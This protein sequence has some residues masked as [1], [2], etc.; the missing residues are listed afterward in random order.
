MLKLVDIKK[1]YVM[2]DTKVEALKGLSINFRRNEFVSILGPSGCG[3]TT[4]LN[5]IGGLDKYTS[6]DLIINGVSTKEF[7]DRNWD[8]YRNHRIGFIFQSYNLIPHQTILE[9]VELALTI[10]GMGKQER[11]EKA[12]NA[13]DRVGLA[14]QYHKRPNQLSGGQCQRVA[15][16]RALVNE[17]E[18]LLADEPTGALDTVTSKQIM[19]LIKE[20][21]KEK[22][23]IMVTHNPDLA[24]EY[25][26]R[27]VRLLDGQINS[28]SNPCS[29]EVET[30]E[31]VV[32][33]EETKIKEKAKMSFWT[34][35]KLS[36]RNL[37]SKFK[38]TLMVGLAGSIGI[39]G[40]S[41]VLAL[42]S[43]ITDYIDNL[44]EDM[45]SGNPITITEQTY[46]LNGMMSS[47]SSFEVAETVIKNGEV[48]VNSMLELLAKRQK[49]MDN[50]FITNEI[51][52][53]Y[54]DYL[55][56]MPK[57]Y[58]E[59]IVYGYGIDITNNIYTNLKEKD[60]S[61]GLD[62]SITAIKQ[63]YKSILQQSDNDDV[64]DASSAITMLSQPMSQAI[65][66]ENYIKEQYDF[67][68]GHMATKADEIMLVVDKNRRITDLTLAEL[69]YYSQESFINFAFGAFDN[70]LGAKIKKL[71]EEKNLNIDELAAL[72]NDN[73][74]AKYENNEMIPSDAT[75]EALATAL[76]VSVDEFNGNF[77]DQNISFQDSFTYEELMNKKFTYY[78]NDVIYKSYTPSFAD[79]WSFVNFEYQPYKN[80]DFTDGL[81][82]KV[83]GILQPKDDVN[84]GTLTTGFYYTPALTDYILE[85][86]LNSEI[87]KFLK[88]H[89]EVIQSGAI[90][91]TGVGGVTTTIYKGVAYHYNFNFNGESFENQTG[92]VGSASMMSIMGD[93]F[94][95]LM[96]NLG[97]G[98]SSSSQGSNVSD[99]YTL[100][101]RNVGGND[102]AN[103]IA[104]YP[105]DFDQKQFVLEY[106][107]K[108]NEEGNLI[109]TVDGK[110]ITVSER[111]KITYTDTLSI[112]IKMVST[113][114]NIVTYALVAFT[115]ISLVVST[116][117]IGIIT[118]VSVVE[119]IK[120]IGVIRSLGGRKKDVAHLFNAE[121][122][123]I[124]GVA[125]V[126]G[127]V[128]TYLISLLANLILGG[129]T[130]VY[131]IVSLKWY[132]AV[133]MITISILLTLI[134]GLFPARSA[135][136]MDPVNALR[137]E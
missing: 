124:G 48:S 15:I 1:T 38:R 122:F 42:S 71:R 109:Y 76:G 89:D 131:T 53:N 117:M 99:I 63:I 62:T 135:A 134:S 95:S 112:V 64:K 39:I 43:G 30:T 108:W 96:D 126:L 110:D 11:L 103:S 21:S 116:V 107:D 32:D 81:E 57:E 17:P 40:V 128:I 130:G 58:I 2:G 59:D 106:L 61:E 31:I 75:K 92:L 36:G 10:A 47:I 132:H 86:N 29:D 45:L 136:K 77:Y 56:A 84:Y 37:L 113:M 115:A 123:I 13:L 111:S 85:K 22:L 90:P 35:F 65:S 27:I 102:L 78:P 51:D 119:R 18:I 41:L 127:I 100:S 20:I 46:D 69:G 83:V 3:K 105:V 74:I 5:I 16:A 101:L 23:V 72:I 66:N 60:D 118:Y 14:G 114:I 129:L 19:D 133:V 121:T 98:G 120:E 24:E 44:Q 91:Y 70:T 88:E 87:A 25:S 6:G 34:A 28:D 125:G 12:Q 94:G 50:L 80:D 9:N 49:Q 33:D 7:N 26:T 55:N 79:S 97:G 52:Q 137:T 93:M 104:I 73:N 82:L 4:L 68:A 67:L 54:I 8:V